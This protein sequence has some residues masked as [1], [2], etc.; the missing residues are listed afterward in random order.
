MSNLILYND[1][2]LDNAFNA[3]FKSDSQYGFAFTHQIKDF[4]NKEDVVRALNTYNFDYLYSIFSDITGKINGVLTV[5]LLKCNIDVL[6]YIHI[7][8]RRFLESYPHVDVKHLYLPNNIMRIE[9]VS[10]LDTDVLIPSS[11]TTIDRGCIK[12]NK[13]HQI[14]FDMTKEQAFKCCGLGKV[15]TIDALASYMCLDQSN[16]VT[17]EFLK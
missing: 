7:L 6:S 17:I 2:D 16:L 14:T 10:I 4:F 1:E 15:S 12:C 5:L 13:K 3:L 8:P 11:V 9:S